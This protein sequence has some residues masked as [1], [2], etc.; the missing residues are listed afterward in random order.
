VKATAKPDY[1]VFVD[2]R[3]IIFELKKLLEDDNF[4]VI[5]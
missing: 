1:C 4:G 5:K 2:G 3:Q